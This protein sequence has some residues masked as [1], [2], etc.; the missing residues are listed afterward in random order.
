MLWACQYPSLPT[1]LQTESSEVLETRSSLDPEESQDSI[2]GKLGK[3]VFCWNYSPGNDQLTYP[4]LSWALL[5]VD[6][7]FI[8]PQVGYVILP[9]PG[10]ERLLG[11]SRSSLHQPGLASQKLKR[12]TK[13]R[14]FS[15]F[16]SRWTLKQIG[17]MLKTTRKMR[18]VVNPALEM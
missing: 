2:P 4:I 11:E 1:P 5:R 15:W 16:L 10:N 13:I 17:A 18:C 6:K 8:C 7:C 12:T 14:V 3:H 9:L